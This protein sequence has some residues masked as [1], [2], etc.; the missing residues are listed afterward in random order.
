VD[1]SN[2][3]ITSQNIVKKISEI[4]EKAIILGGDHSITYSCFKGFAKNN[5]DG[6]IIIF[7]AHPDCENM[8]SP[9]TQEDL[10]IVL[11]KE[12]LVDPKKVILI[13]T[14]N[15]SGNERE[16]L[17]MHKIRYFSMKQI[18]QTSIQAVC[19]TVMETAV[20]WPSLYI[21]VDIDV[22]DPA[23]APGTGYIEP[24]GLTSREL[25]YFLQRLKLLKNFKMADIVEVNPPKDVNNLT[26]KLGA[27]LVKEL[28]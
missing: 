14:R 9:P 4:K 24:A 2:I 21:S 17:E 11:I 12:G 22:V 15:M 16:F 27:K 28:S 8:F 10:L 18:F 19:D 25:V 5:P 6:G 20:Q 7:D 26:S 13:G 3:E 23:F 1:N